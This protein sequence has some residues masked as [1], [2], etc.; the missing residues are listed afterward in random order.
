MKESIS[1]N[2]TSP[3]VVVAEALAALEQGRSNV[4][5]GVLMN[6]L[7]VNSARF[8]PREVLTNAVGRLFQG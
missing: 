6:Q 8:L 5:P 2:Y 4:V 1:Q 3:E 7:M